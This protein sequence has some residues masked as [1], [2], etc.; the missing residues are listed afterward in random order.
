MA[1]LLTPV[2]GGSSVTD[3]PMDRAG[4]PLG[5]CGG[6]QWKRRRECQLEGQNFATT[7][8]PGSRVVVELQGDG[9]LGSLL[10]SDS[11]ARNPQ[12]WGSWSPGILGP[13]CLVKP[14]PATSGRSSAKETIYSL[15]LRKFERRAVAKVTKLG[16]LFLTLPVTV[17]P[18]PTPTSWH[19]PLPPVGSCPV[20]LLHPPSP[21]PPVP[22]PLP[23]PNLKPVSPVGL[24]HG[25]TMAEKI[26]LCV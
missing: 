3:R 15:V 4:S 25:L 20:C 13:K 5:W 18:G 9:V 6:S 2:P 1:S 10:S 14:S 21:L 23:V 22:D 26:L 19:L 24:T 7:A 16:D 17:C 11:M 8:W 12:G